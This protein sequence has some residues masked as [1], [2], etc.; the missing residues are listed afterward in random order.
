MSILTQ[1]PTVKVEIG[2]ALRLTSIAASH[3]WM[4][5]TFADTAL[6][7]FERWRVQT[8]DI[9]GPNDGGAQ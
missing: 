2:D 4:G 3:R 9:G 8:R 7:V 5:I 6:M 1:C